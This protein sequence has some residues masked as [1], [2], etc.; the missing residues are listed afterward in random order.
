MKLYEKRN[1]ETRGPVGA[2]ERNDRAPGFTIAELLDLFYAEGVT[3]NFAPADLGTDESTEVDANG[4]MVVDPFGNIR[5]DSLDL[6][7]MQLTKVFEDGKQ[8]EVSGDFENEPPA[9]DD[10]QQTE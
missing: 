7:E 10:P 2:F 4:R 3:P 6:K 5:T 9:N 1:K 8:P